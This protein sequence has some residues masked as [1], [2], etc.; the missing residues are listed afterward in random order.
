MKKILIATFLASGILASHQESQ[1][2]STWTGVGSSGTP[3]QWSV[4]S[5]WSVNAP[6]SNSTISLL[7]NNSVNSWSNND[8][9]GLTVTDVSI[10]STFGNATNV[11]D[12]TITGNDIV[13][14]GNVTISTGNW[15][16]IYLNMAIDG[17]RTFSITS[18]QLTI[19]DNATSGILSDGLT[20][21]GIIKTGNSWLILNGSNTYTGGTQLNGGAIQINNA[22]ALGTTGTLSFGGGYLRYGT[23][24]TNDL[25][26]RFSTA[27]GQNYSVDTNG[28]NVV[29]AT[30][31]TS[32]NGNF[33]KSGAGT[34]SFNAVN[35]YNGTTT[36]SGGTLQLNVGGATG[37]IRG[38]LTINSGATVVSA[39]DSSFGYNAG[40]KVNA[41]TINNGNLTHTPAGTTL[42]LASVAVTMT[43][44]TMNS[45]VSNGFDFF[46]Q[47]GTN[48]SV[49]TLANATSA[50]IAGIVNLRAG[51]ND[52]TGTVFTVA[53]GAAADDLVVSASLRNGQ[54][55]GINSIVQKSGAG[56]M[57]LSGNNS[58]TGGTI[59]NAGTLA[60]TSKT[61]LGA[62]ST[63]TFFSGVTLE[64]ATSDGSLSNT[65]NLNMG[66]N[67]FSTTVLNRATTGEA[68]Y[69]LG[70][71]SLGSS[72]MTFNRGANIS[73]NASVTIGALD[74][75]AGNNDRPVILNG[76]ATINVGSAG[77]FSNNTTNKRLQLDGT[78][79]NNTIGVISNGN[80]TAVLSLI[81]EGTGTWTLSANNT[82]TGTTTVTTGTLLVNGSTSASSAV[83]VGANGT[84][85]G[86]GTVG[87]FTTVN[88]NLRPGNSPGVQTFS[89]GL[90][91]AGTA[92]F[93]INGIAVRGTDFD[94][95]NVTGGTTT[96]GG[97]LVFE[98]GNLSAL[99]NSTDINLF[100]YTGSSLGDFTSLT[101]TGFY[102]GTWTSAGDNDKWTLNSGGQTL[103]FSETT[104]N[105]SVVPE[106]STWALVG[107][108]V[109]VVL[110]GFRRRKSAAHS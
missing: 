30:G 16:N 80:G 69:T 46:D 37:A 24:I 48:T 44:G 27:A 88:G 100:S 59:L 3:A 73:G 108:G 97:A 90:T 94:G 25:S 89:N 36:V 6:S 40:V 49:N 23:G 9:A 20:A 64:L 12:N 26:S 74:L 28:N 17:V 104:G 70:N 106:P 82:Y 76:N 109:G 47:S 10:P 53:D 65:Y 87:G 38:N 66:S 11:R 67:R 85:G 84:L 35:T 92:T 14:A 72:T 83:T 102:S 98:F 99:S 2:Q 93:E 29:H 77:I 58:Y 95:I 54:F 21:G 75:S 8:L 45:T 105:L 63:V 61:G 41:L 52:S 34:L 7:F 81:K 60:V 55:Q 18:G 50:T 91:L 96:L 32:A 103:T 79:T 39:A 22:N 51:D 110:F 62:N 107:L 15:Q 101:S 43:G 31:L 19:G 86:S 5:N 42:T 56:R 57:V 71:F 4:G 13:L 68:S 33:T 1:A 78:A